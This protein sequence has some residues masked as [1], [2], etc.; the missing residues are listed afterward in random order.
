MLLRIAE[1][2]QQ[3]VLHEKESLDTI[4][5]THLQ[6]K[7]ISVCR[8]SDYVTRTNR[9]CVTYILQALHK[10]EIFFNDFSTSRTR[11]EGGRTLSGV[12]QYTRRLWT[13]PSSSSSTRRRSAENAKEH[14]AKGKS[15]CTCGVL[16]QELS[17]EK[18]KTLKDTTAQVMIRLSGLQWQIRTRGQSRRFRRPRREAFSKITKEEFRRLCRKMSKKTQ[19]IGS[20]CEKA[21]ARTKH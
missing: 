16:L 20:A 1:T 6:S 11:Y 17:T 13:S 21:A 15:C 8:V 9:N 18:T 12:M 14:N 4:K 19:T 3:H 2:F 7:Q 5:R 10:K